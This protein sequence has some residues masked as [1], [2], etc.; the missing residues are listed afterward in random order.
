MTRPTPS[1]E[2]PRTSAATATAEKKLRYAPAMPL[3]PA[4]FYSRPDDPPTARAAGE[5]TARAE[6]SPLAI[7]PRSARHAVL[8]LFA[9][10]DY[11]NGLTDDEAGYMA[12]HLSQ[13]SLAG[14]TV[15]P[16]AAVRAAESGRRRV[17]DLVRLGVITPIGKRRST[18]PVT[19]VGGTRVKRVC[20]ITPQGHLALA[21]LDRNERWS[22]T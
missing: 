15:L 13:D 8:A 19:I 14:V 18:L 17:S 20:V 21:Q 12:W 11:A 3:D 4:D 6:G 7:G 1:A 10:V 2:R 22:P 5:A 9:L 16:T